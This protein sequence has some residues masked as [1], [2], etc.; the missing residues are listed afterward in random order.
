MVVLR[1]DGGG[2]TGATSRCAD[3]QLGLSEVALSFSFDGVGSP[4]KGLSASSVPIDGGERAGNSSF[5]P[6]TL[7]PLLVIPSSSC[8]LPDSLSLSNLREAVRFLGCSTL[9]GGL[10]S[11]ATEAVR[12]RVFGGR[13]AIGDESSMAKNVCCAKLKQ[14]RYREGWWCRRKKK[15]KSRGN[16]LKGLKRVEQEWV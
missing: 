5:L 9:G 11:E 14:G 1:L 6:T 13:M 7:R 2:D 8:S 10:G 15:R 4:V 12:L 3:R 16:G